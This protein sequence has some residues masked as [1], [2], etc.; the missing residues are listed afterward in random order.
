MVIGANRITVSYLFCFRLTS[1]YFTLLTLNEELNPY[2]IETFL[3][4]S[5]A[6]INEAALLSARKMSGNNSCDGFIHDE[7]LEHY[8]SMLVSGQ[9][10]TVNVFYSIRD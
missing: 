8:H 6:V 2:T 9:Y 1:S 3:F 5:L 4:H 7:K 10:D